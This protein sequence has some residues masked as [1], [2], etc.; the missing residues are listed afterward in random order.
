V[1]AGGHYHARH[2]VTGPQRTN[3]GTPPAGGVP[4]LDIP[5]GSAL[6]LPGNLRGKAA[7]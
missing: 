6:P 2:S 7:C 5:P 4:F 3:D 1:I